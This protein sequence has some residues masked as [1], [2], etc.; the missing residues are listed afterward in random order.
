VPLQAPLE[1][2]AGSPKADIDI[3]VKP[4]GFK[5]AMVR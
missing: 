4:S 3:E 5:V 1:V 2:L